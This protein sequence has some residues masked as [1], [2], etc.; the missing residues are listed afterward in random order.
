METK[1][2]KKTIK[3]NFLEQLQTCLEEDSTVEIITDTNEIS[4]KLSVI[5]SDYVGVTSS[6]ERSV[7][8]SAI[9]QD[10]VEEKEQHI[11]VYSLETF[12]KFEDIKA[13]SRVLNKAIK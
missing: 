10:K 7:E 8:V 9:G 4:G 13:V 6:S 2:A 11:E 5:G 1:S 3:I 12:V